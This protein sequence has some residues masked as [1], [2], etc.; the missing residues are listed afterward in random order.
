MKTPLVVIVGRPNVGKSTLFNRLT[1]TQNSI[2]DDYSGVTRDRVYG[3]VEWNGENFKLI[4]TGGFVP[5]SD[6]I[7]ESAIREQIQ[8][9]LEEA[10]AILFITDGRTGIHP[11]DR[12]IA[13]RLRKTE[14]PVFVLVNKSDNN[15]LGLSKNEFYEF[16]LSD[17]FD[18]SAL[19]GR[20]V[21]NVL[22]QLLNV[23]PEFDNDRTE[24]LRL[25]IA[26]VG[27]PN[28]G[29][30]SLTNS[31]TGIDRSIVTDI[32]G[33]TRDSL[34]TVLKYY[35]EE[36]ILIDTAGLRKKSK[37]REN[38]EFYSTVRTYRA[39]SESDVS[40]VLLDA[41][42]GVEK[43]D[44]QII[45]ET[46]RRRKGLIIAVNKWDLIEKETNT[47]KIYEDA[48][49]ESLG[50]IDY[51]PII[52]VSA[53]T[54]QRIFKLI[55]LAKEIESERK[56]KIPTNQLNDILL[57][58]L[59]KTPPPATPT[60]KEVKIRF[61]NQVGEKYPI[62]LVFANNSKHIPDHYRRFV[63]KKIR[64]HFGYFGVPI[65]VSFKDS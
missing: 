39:I 65:T 10:D 45:D 23:L 57:P 32:P 12:E 2:V 58:E 42:L 59:D 46:V 18:I 40:I 60:G 15:E 30:S 13:D 61:I 17:V 33:T 50:K 48:I 28:V 41:N 29:K 3:E 1:K 36:I 20:N 63:E 38:I 24:D 56:K 11:I 54:K 4:D 6:E 34:D 7:F 53:L 19:S 27:K 51:A 25:K 26:I 49:R 62:F 14:K 44:K 64:Q 8:I 9:A 22:D 37:I 21:G 55:D 16:G 35:G 47:A 52:F 31:L 5:L 43:Q